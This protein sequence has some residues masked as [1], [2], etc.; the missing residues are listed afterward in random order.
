MNRAYIHFATQTDH[1]RQNAWANVFLKLRL[2]Q[3]L[4]DGHQFFLSA[5][6]VLL[7]QGPIPLKHL[8]PINK[9]DIA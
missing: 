8:E 6:H 4:Q 2:A 9:D 1:M 5:N 7:T 3:A